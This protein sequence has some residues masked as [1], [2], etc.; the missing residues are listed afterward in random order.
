VAS[1]ISYQHIQKQERHHYFI[2]NTQSITTT[3]DTQQHNTYGKN[4]ELQFKK[5]CE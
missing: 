5:T 2:S 1:R 3:Q 4:K